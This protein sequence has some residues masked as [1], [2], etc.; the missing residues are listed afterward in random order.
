M[1]EEKRHQQKEYIRSLEKQR[2]TLIEQHITMI[3]LLKRSKQLED[4]KAQLEEKLS[5]LQREGMVQNYTLDSDIAN[6]HWPL[7]DG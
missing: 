7:I 6:M 4:E 3:E 5:M 1:D 2:D